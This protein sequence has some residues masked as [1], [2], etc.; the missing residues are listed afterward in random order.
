MTE[1]ARK[2]RPRRQCAKCPWKVS[3]DPYEIPD[4]Y[5]SIKHAGLKSTIA[6]PGS[7]RPGPIRLMACHESSARREAPCVGWLAHQLGE[8][9]N[10]ALRLY[11]MTGKVDGNIETVGPQHARFEDTLPDGSGSE[12]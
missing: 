10:I 4:G 8:G 12:D 7:L 2:K 9:N 6:E 1:R 11:V 3:T 5:C